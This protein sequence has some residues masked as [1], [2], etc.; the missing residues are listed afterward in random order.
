MTTLARVLDVGLGWLFDTVQPDDAHQHHLGIALGLPEYNRTYG[1]CPDGAE[2][3]PVVVVSVAKPRLL[4]G[5]LQQHP[6]TPLELA[7]LAA[8]LRRRGLPI[9]TTWNG[10]PAPTGSVGLAQPVHYTL[11]AAVQRYH[12][13]CTS[14]PERRVFCDCEHWRAEGA[15]IIRPARPTAEGPPS[16]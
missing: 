15:R 16:G 13:G 4:P 9:R 10:F 2:H 1:F 3:L 8:E 6:L 5:R 14:H 11:A 12:R 7:D